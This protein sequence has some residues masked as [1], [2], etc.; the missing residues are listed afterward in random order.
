MGSTKEIWLS[1]GGGVNTDSDMGCLKIWGW[2]QLVMGRYIS[3]DKFCGVF[4]EYGMGSLKLILG[5]HRWVLISRVRDVDAAE[6][7]FYLLMR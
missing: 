6:V 5:G 1:E 3:W 7:R 2:L 4:A